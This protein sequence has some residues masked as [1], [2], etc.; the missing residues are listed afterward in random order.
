MPRRRE[1]IVV[2][3]RLDGSRV[4]LHRRRVLEFHEIQ[5]RPHRL[6]PVR[7]PASVATSR[8]AWVP[9]ADHPW[10]RQAD[11]DSRLRAARRAAA[12]IRRELRVEAL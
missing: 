9:P 4:L 10:R 3:R 7:K 8:P 1:R 12:Q 5:Q 6:A 11:T 2:R